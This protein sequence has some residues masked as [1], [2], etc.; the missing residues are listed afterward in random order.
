MVTTR[1]N[2]D[3]DVPNFEAMIT[4]A[5]AN[6]L[7]NLTAALRTQITNDIR[8]GAGPSGGGGGDAIP[9]GIHVWIE[10][11]T[12]LKPL[13]FR[14]AATPA[15][16]EDWIT[17]MEKLFQVLGCPD[18]F[19]TRLA[20][21]KLEGD[22][23]T[24]GKLILRTQVE[25]DA[26]AE[27][28]TWVCLVREIFYNRY[29]P[30]S[31]Q[32]R[33]ER[34]Y[35]SICQLDRENS[36][37]YMERFTRLAS[38]VGATARDA[39]RQ[40]RHFKWGLKKWV[41]D[42]IVNTDY[43]NVCA[44]LYVL[45][46]VFRLAICFLSISR[47]LMWIL[48]MDWLASHRATIDCYA[49][50]VIFGNVRQ[51]EFVY[52]GSSPLK[53]VK[54]ISAM[55]AYLDSHGCQE[56]A[57]VFFP[58]ELRWTSPAREIELAFGF[59]FPADEK[60]RE[61]VSSV[62]QIYSDASKKG[63]VCVLMQAC[64]RGS[65]GYWASMRIESNLMLQIKEAQRDDGELWAIVQNVED[66]KHTEISVVIDG[67]TKMYRDLKH[68]FWWNG[69]KQDVATFL[70]GNGMAD[71]HGFRYWVWP[72]TQKRHDALWV[73]VIANQVCSVL[74]IQNNYGIISVAE[75]S[76]QKS[77]RRICM[78]HRLYCVRQ[79][80]KFNVSFLEKITESYGTVCK[81]LQTFHPAKPMV[82][83]KDH[84]DF[85]DYVEAWSGGSSRLLMKM[86]VAKEKLKEARSRQKS[87]ADKHR[88]DL[89]FQVGDRRPFGD[90]RLLARGFVSSMALPPQFSLICLCTRRI[91]ES[92][93]DLQ[94]RVM[95]EKQ[96]Y[97]FVK[98]LWKE[99]PIA[100]RA[101]LGDT[102]VRSK[103]GSD[104]ELLEFSL[105]IACFR[106]KVRYSDLIVKVSHDI[107]P[108][109]AA[110]SF[111]AADVD[112]PIRFDDRIR[113]ANLLPIH[114]F[115]F[116]VI[117]G[118]DWLAS[119]RAMLC[120]LRSPMIS[121]M[122]LNLQVVFSASEQQRYERGMDRYVSLARENL[123]STWRVSLDWLVLLEL[124]AGV[125]PRCKE[126]HV[127]ANEVGCECEIDGLLIRLFGCWQ[128]AVAPRPTERERESLCQG[129]REYRGRQA[130]SV[131]HWGLRMGVMIR[132]DWIFS[133]SGS[134]VYLGREWESIM[135]PLRV[136]GG[137]MLRLVIRRPRLQK[138]NMNPTPLIERVIISTPMKNHM[139]IDHEYVN[140]PLRLMI[141][142]VPANLLPIHMLDFDVILGMDWLASHRA[143]ID[144]YA[145]TVIFDNVRQP[146]FVYHGSSP[147]KSVKLIS[148]M[149]ARTLISHG[150]QGFLA[151]LWNIFGEVLILKIFLVVRDSP[152]VFPMNFLDFLRLER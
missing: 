146:E 9:Q 138:L 101:Y 134:E 121:G 57:D 68:Y 11:F 106:N 53:S 78:V 79:D 47:H 39:Q 75:I 139:L 70:C 112:C 3:D 152:D 109:S 111:P 17:H 48:C 92:I 133:G 55:K 103:E 65:G 22:A 27:T 105:I 73:L 149:K 8:N 34:E 13:A 86:A 82:S 102:E 4:A 104:F 32:Q 129:K 113:P 123:G 72:T 12:K 24:G 46:I 94:E 91:P 90:I 118:M 33:Y 54:L 117:L 130:R 21:F 135:T 81:S 51:P 18:N 141:I 10:R 142:F 28:C 31:E 40:A 125:W 29:F 19:K 98:I 35:G 119:H 128:F 126:F 43:T 30:A 140:C 60:G 88:R 124:S 89:E 132:N 122:V 99:S 66:G 150:C 96:S 143:T 74:T 144:C 127:G 23:E 41:L 84:S 107:L 116:D 45:M 80:P 95:G 87:Y 93:L 7:P 131:E 2:S 71:F 97:S 26:F 100:V 52:H 25:V 108:L 137:V 120:E 77:L 44:A 36:G 58:D 42:R 5:V 56:F 136:R 38:F 69:M 6:A 62:Y 16:A 61:V 110:L 114:M 76:R 50:T 115:D 83:Q 14:S 1:R 148:A 15:E 20:A 67:S 85:E 145:R 59:R 151:L 63:L 147:L 64:V 49:R 37:E